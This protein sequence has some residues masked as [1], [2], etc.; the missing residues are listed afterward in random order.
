MQRKIANKVIDRGFGFPVILINVPMCKIDGEWV[1]NVN[2]NNLTKSV[3][4]A[5]ADSEGRLTGNQVR[6]IRQ[7]F[8]MTLTAFSDRFGLSH[9]AVIKWE[10]AGDKPTSMTWSTEKDIRLFIKKQIKI[11]QK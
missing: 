9:P 2:Y 4:S 10:K 7:H 1:I 6:F 11:A 8:E 3:L 5:L